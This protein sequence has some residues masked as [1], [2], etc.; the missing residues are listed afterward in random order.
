MISCCMQV[1]SGLYVRVE[2]LNDFL[3]GKE[4]D[5]APL[6]PVKAGGTNR[7]NRCTTRRTELCPDT[8][9]STSRLERIL[10]TDVRHIFLDFV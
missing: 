8:V 7:Q 2:R 4:R 1:I 6:A 10:P 3:A 5:L 9:P